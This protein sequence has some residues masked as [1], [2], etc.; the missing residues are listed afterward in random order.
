MKIN[1]SSTNRVAENY[2]FQLIK[3]EHPEWV[4]HDGSC[5]RCEDYYRILDKLVSLENV[6]H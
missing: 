4:E 3:E 5:K 6:N 2:V 1:K